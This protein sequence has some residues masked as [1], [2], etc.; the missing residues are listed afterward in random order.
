MSASTATTAKRP[1]EP[2]RRRHRRLRWILGGAAA[3][4]VLLVVGAAVAVRLQ[5][6]TAPLALPNAGATPAGPIDGVWHPTAG[7][8]AGFRIPQTILG[9]TSDVVGRT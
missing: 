1:D 5:P 9:M 6:T 3:V 2:T 8:V 7:S 4:L